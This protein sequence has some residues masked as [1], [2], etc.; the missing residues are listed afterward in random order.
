MI[1]T[2]NFFKLALSVDNVIFGF[3]GTDLRVLLIKRG[4]PPFEN[5]WALPGDLVYPDEALDSAATRVL[6][7]LTGL[8]EVFLEQ[9]HSFGKVDRHPLG[10]VITVAYYS[11]IN[12][13]NYSPNPSSWAREIS[14]HKVKE[15]PSLAFDHENILCASF[16]KLKWKVRSQPVGFEL[17]PKEFTLSQL[18]QLYEAILGQ[19]LD[20]R[21][22]RRKILSMDLLQDTGVIQSGVA[23]RPAKL[24]RFDKKKYAILESN[25]YSFDL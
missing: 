22:F 19:E 3:D 13:E 12:I 23:H 9:V 18:R 4:T 1:S 21:N 16:D 6:R 20:K 2:D 5:M 17:L 25:G 14:W 11:L 8:S 7:E 24:F 15:Q 10:R